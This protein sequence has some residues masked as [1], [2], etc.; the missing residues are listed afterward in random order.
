MSSYLPSRGCNVAGINGS[1]GRCPVKVDYKPIDT[2]GNNPKF[3]PAYAYALYVRG[4]LGRSGYHRYVVGNQQLNNVGSYQGAP[5]N[6]V[7]APPRNS[8]N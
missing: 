4:S 8:F 1:D 7:R 5:G 6:G 2:G 3:N